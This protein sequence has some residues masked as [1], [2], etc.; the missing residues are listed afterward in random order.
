MKRHVEHVMGLPVSLALRGRHED[1]ARA[2]AAWAD[3]VAELRRVDVVFSPYRPDSAVSRIAR[4]EDVELTE[5]IAEVV[6]LGERA[7]ADSDG[8]F[9]IWRDGPDGRRRFD[10]SGVVKG[11]AVQ[12]AARALAAL[13]HTDWS[14]NAGGDVLCRTVR[15]DAPPWRVGIEDPHD[16]SR[17]LAVVPVWNGAV[18][19]SGTAARGEHIVDAR[20]GRPP[21]GLASVTVVAET[22]TEADVDATAAFALGERAGEFL[23]SRGRL[24]LTVAAGSPQSVHEWGPGRPKERTP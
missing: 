23:R 15:A 6:A 19:T 24:Y 22:L 5:E 10:P 7:E 21:A 9:S 18:A 20:T 2:E 11:W 8:A 13:E 16:R 14:V 17:V 12:R 3:L 1:D 4:G